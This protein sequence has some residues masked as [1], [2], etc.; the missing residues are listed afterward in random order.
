MR[1]DSVITDII[2]KIY[3]ENKGQI[4][5]S[6]IIRILN[7]Y[8]DGLKKMISIPYI[9]KDG[10]EKAISIKVDFYGK[11]VANDSRKEKLLIG[12]EGRI[13]KLREIHRKKKEE[14]ERA[15][16]EVNGYKPRN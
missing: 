12:K 11:F 14:R 9:D 13:A 16:Y 6:K 15:L 8:Y 3:L 7:K 2:N 10:N 5:H 4:S 1:I